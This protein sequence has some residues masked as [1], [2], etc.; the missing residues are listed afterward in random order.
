MPLAHTGF[1]SAR[2]TWP[3]NGQNGC[4]AQVGPEGTEAAIDAPLLPAHRPQIGCSEVGLGPY[5]RVSGSASLHSSWSACPREISSN[6]T[7]SAETPCLQGKAPAA[8][9]PGR[10]EDFL[11]AT[12]T[13]RR[14]QRHHAGMP[15]QTNTKYNIATQ[16][17]AVRAAS[18]AGEAGCA[19]GRSAT[20]CRLHARSTARCSSFQ[21]D[22]FVI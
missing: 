15:L 5:P 22:V 6:V 17:Q 20:R 10:P 9:D 19:R 3:P 14:R 21:E 11:D 1:G 12:P 4:E 16:W 13:R 8:T 2:G 7:S 18:D